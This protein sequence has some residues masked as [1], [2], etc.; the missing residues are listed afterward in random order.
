MG[1]DAFFKAKEYTNIKLNREEANILYKAIYF[2]EARI[3][4]LSFGIRWCNLT[5]SVKPAMPCNIF[6]NKYF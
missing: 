3:N 5:N 4:D 1:N 2:F 6:Y